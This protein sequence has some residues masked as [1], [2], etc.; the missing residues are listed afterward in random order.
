MTAST[1]SFTD[2][3]AELIG[4]LLLPGDPGYPELATPWNVAVPSAPVAVVAAAA[5]DRLAEARAMAERWGGRSAEVHCRLLAV[6]WAV[7]DRGGR[8]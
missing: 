8:G 7:A 6:E 2:L 5:R 1:L 3:A 4:R